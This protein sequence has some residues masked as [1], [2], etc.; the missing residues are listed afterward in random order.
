MKRRSIICAIAF[1]SLLGRGES[2]S[3]DKVFFMELPPTVLPADVGGNAF[4]IVGGFPDGGALYWMPTSGTTSIGGRTG[5]AVS[6]DG[7]TIVGNALDSRG[8]ENAAIWKRGTEWR[9]LG[10]F[11]PDAQP[12]DQNLS[13]AYGTN[14]DGSVIVGLGWDGC[15][16]AHAFRWDDVTGVVDLGSTTA[17]SSRANGVSGDGNIVIGWQED[18]TGFRQG[19]AWLNGRQ[20]L[21]R[22]PKGPSFPVGEAFGANHDGSVIVGQVCDRTDTTTTAAWTW[23]LAQGV[24]CFPVERPATLPPLPYIARMLKTSDDGRVIGGGY[25]FGLESEALIWLDGQVYFLKE[26]LRQNGYPDAFRGWVNTGTVTSVSPDGRTLVGYGAGPRT[27]TGYLVILP[28][29]GQK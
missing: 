3:D 7:K 17:N 21:F 1:F 4:A 29:R 2:A 10:S 16:V 12:C 5:V 23:T 27:F 25:S 11:T 14:A 24:Q 22:G 15:K 18:G 26:Y 9:V 28:K 20:T 19:A 13:A 6:H 8:L